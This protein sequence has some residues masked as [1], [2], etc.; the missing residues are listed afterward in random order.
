MSRNAERA[1]LCGLS[2]Q[3]RAYL[4]YSAESKDWVNGLVP[5]FFFGRILPTSSRRPYGYGLACP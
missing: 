4:R 1:A 3:D 5:D 2:P